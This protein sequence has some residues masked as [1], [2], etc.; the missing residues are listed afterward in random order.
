VVSVCLRLRHS[1]MERVSKRIGFL[2]LKCRFHPMKFNQVHLHQ[3]TFEF[4]VPYLCLAR[5]RIISWPIL[6]LASLR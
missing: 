6:V 4:D 2:N 1:V 3:G 5:A